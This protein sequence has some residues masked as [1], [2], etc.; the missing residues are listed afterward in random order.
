MS[1]GLVNSVVQNCRKELKKNSLRRLPVES[2][3]S[4]PGDGTTAV[5]GGG[6]FSCKESANEVCNG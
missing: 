4:L 2:S 6:F 3:L 1:N 5:T